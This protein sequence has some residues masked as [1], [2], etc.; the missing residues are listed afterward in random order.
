MAITTIQLEEETVKIL[1]M[2][3]EQHELKTYDEAIRKI[4]A[5]R[6]TEIEKFK[7]FLGKKD[8]AFIMK[9]LRDKKDREF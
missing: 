1:K 9:G 2:Y 6:K 3:K 5:A 8:M 7:G 4:L